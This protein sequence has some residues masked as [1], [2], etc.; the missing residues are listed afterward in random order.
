M[1]T[2][3]RRTMRTAGLARASRRGFSMVEVLIS[4]AISATLLTATLGALDGSFKAYKVTT[5][6]AST[7]V[8]ARIVMQ[9]LT[10]MIRTG[11]SFGP[12]PVNP[13]TNPEIES[14][15]I[16]FVSYR[17]S[18]SNTERVTRLE[19]RD[20]PVGEGPYELWYLVTTYT[21]GAF[22]N[23]DAAPLLTNLNDVIFTME[24][25]VGP[26]LK[27]VTV[28]LIIQPDDLQDV[29]IGTH[30]EAPVIRL[31]ASA[32]PRMND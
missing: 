20:G 15:W 10:A 17:D 25:D 2:L 21:N 4:L 29:A 23:E 5:E 14:S 1:N 16:E 11:E 6:G 12:Y 28:D 8:V 27:R 3:N 26:R 24:Y 32:S 31:V 13:I 7:N 22:V 18:I 30:L 9:R 19:R